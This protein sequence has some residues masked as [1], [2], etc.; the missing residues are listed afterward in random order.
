MSEHLSDSVPTIGRLRATEKTAQF[1]NAFKFVGDVASR[2]RENPDFTSD[3]LR[4]M[5]E[6][7][8]NSLV[9]EVV[10]R[11]ILGQVELLEESRSSVFGSAAEIKRLKTLFEETG[12]FGD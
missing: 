10:E 1:L 2:A 7:L 5:M 3:G 11:L 12:I 8:P 6:S 9:P 4:E